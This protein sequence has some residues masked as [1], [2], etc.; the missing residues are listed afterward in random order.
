MDAERWVLVRAIK[1]YDNHEVGDVFTVPMTEATAHLVVSTYLQ[2][3]DDP[4]WHTQSGSTE[5][6]S[7]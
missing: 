4:V 7:T 2:L 3:L 1:A 5:P 6:S